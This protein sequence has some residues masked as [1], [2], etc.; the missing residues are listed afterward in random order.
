MDPAFSTCIIPIT[1]D[2]RYIYD[3]SITDGDICYFSRFKKLDFEPRD[4]QKNIAVPG[5]RTDNKVEILRR[6]WC[7]PSIT[8][9]GIEHSFD[10][11]G[12]PTLV[13]RKVSQYTKNLLHAAFSRGLMLRYFEV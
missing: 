7:L 13:S 9:H 4:Y 2:K 8:I 10:K 11:P 1:T 5:L 6:R 12:A 3:I